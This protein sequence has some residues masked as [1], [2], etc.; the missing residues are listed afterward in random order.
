MVWLADTVLVVHALLAPGSTSQHTSREHN[1][2]VTDASHLR[3][4]PIRNIQQDC[5]D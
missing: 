2:P 3:A 5:A 4:A 1:A